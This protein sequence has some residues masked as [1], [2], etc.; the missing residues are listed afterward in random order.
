MARARA[1]NNRVGR[2]RRKGY[3]T[4]GQKTKDAIADLESRPLRHASLQLAEIPAVA[5]EIA[6]LAAQFAAFVARGGVIAVAEIPA[7]LTSIVSDLPP[8]VPHTA[9]QCPVAVRGQRRGCGHR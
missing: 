8:V 3:T 5:G 6:V 7:Q 1:G 4:K 9:P 2:K